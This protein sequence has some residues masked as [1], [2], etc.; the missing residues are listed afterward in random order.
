MLIVIY[1]NVT[2]DTSETFIGIQHI[3]WTFAF[4]KYAPGVIFSTLGIICGIFI[5]TI[6]LIQKIASPIYVIALYA[7]SIPFIAATIRKKNK[8]MGAFE[9][10]HNH[11]LKIVE[12][13][14][15]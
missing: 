13:L 14:E 9:H 1:H 6:T 11:T 4:R 8:C 2:T 3:Y 15:R 12:F 5:T 7:I 10:L